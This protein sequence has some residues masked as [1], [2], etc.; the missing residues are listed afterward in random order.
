MNQLTGPIQSLCHNVNESSVHA[1]TKKNFLVDWK[2]LVEES[3]AHISK[4]LDVLGFLSF[5]LTGDMQQ[6]KHDTLHM[7]LYI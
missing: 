1:I 7:A 3:I 6:V 2:F 5:R 4:P